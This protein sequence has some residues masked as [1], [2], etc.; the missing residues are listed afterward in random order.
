MLFSSSIF[1]LG[2]LL[3][4]TL[5]PAAN[6]QLD[7]PG[8]A[9]EPR[10]AFAAH[11]PLRSLRVGGQFPSTVHTHAVGGAAERAAGAVRPGGTMGAHQVSFLG[12]AESSLGDAKCSLGDA[13]SSLGDAESSLGDAESSLGDAKR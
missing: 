12:D 13:E 1:V 3:Q 2:L 9:A 4:Q 10:A 6:A 8:R 5:Q 7:W 11:Q